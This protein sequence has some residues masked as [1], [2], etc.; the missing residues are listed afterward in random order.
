MLGDILMDTEHDLMALQDSPPNLIIEV[1]DEALGKLGCVVIDKLVRGTSAG[2]VRF[3]W[4]TSPDE[5]ASVV[6][7]KTYSYAFLNVPLGGAKAGI[8]ADP[9]QLGCDRVTVMEAFGR[10]I[11]PLVRQQVYYPGTNMGTT[12]DDLGAIMRGAGRPLVG[13]QINH[14]FCTGLTVFE[15]IRQ[16][17]HFNGLDLTNLRVA[18]EGFGRVGSVVAQLLAQAGARLI[19]LS[20][21]RGAL[22][23]E[24]GLEVSRL[25]SLK[26]QYGGQLVHQYSGAHVMA[27]EALFTQH[28]DLLM[29][30]ARAH[31]IH[32]GNAD[33]VQAKL[34]V[35]ISYAPMTPE[36]EQMLVARGVV[37]MPDFVANCGGVLAADMRGAGFDV[38][39]V[40]R[41][42]EVTFAEVV[43]SIL[44]TARREGQPVGKIART[45]AWQNYC[46]LNGSAPIPPNRIGQVLQVLKSQGWS[47]V[48]RRLAWRAQHRWP[49][50][51][52]AILRAAVDRYTE[53]TLGA[54]LTRVG[55]FRAGNSSQCTP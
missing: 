44:Q 45:L 35:P 39:D 46:E 27:C 8:W 13:Q 17:A 33:Q 53:M 31:V 26:Q 10:A 54:T 41:V 49:R 43:T 48:W 6:R 32:A 11:A 19:A 4:G 23:A 21:S 1:F 55:S 12:L 28:V 15:T 51:N 30:G 36:A 7:S 2:G 40:R 24:G 16:V 52:G 34:I 18:I 25:L 5:L 47:G 50:L 42:V 37:V 38:E 14:S 20:T 29:P 22:V 9:H 3:K